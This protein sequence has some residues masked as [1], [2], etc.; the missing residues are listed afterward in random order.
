MSRRKVVLDTNLYIDWLNRGLR[1]DVILAED[2]IRYLS[3]VVVMELRAG[4]T[5]L[6]A[7]RAVDKLLR[8]YGAARRLLVPTASQF[9]L[10]GDVLQRLRKAGLEVRRS[11]L[12]DDVL[13]ALTARGIG[14]A[15][16]TANG[17]FADIGAAVDVVVERVG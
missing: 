14:A 2:E 11:S 5:T 3:A 15:V 1:E 6:P 16:L 10:A 4:A 8:A 7:R 12:V 17:D 9:E 13:I